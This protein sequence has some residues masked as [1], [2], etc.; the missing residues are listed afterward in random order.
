MRSRID[1]Q[2]QILRAGIAQGPDQHIG[3]AGAAEARNEN[4][5]SI[6]NIGK[7]LRGRIYTLVDWHTAGVSPGH[8]AP[9]LQPRSSSQARD[10]GHAGK[11][12]DP[13]AINDVV[14]A[15]AGAAVVGR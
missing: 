15:G 13:A 14:L 1:D 2:S 9:P 7:S 8:L 3:E 5:C 10:L 12:S 11:S 4:R 6:R